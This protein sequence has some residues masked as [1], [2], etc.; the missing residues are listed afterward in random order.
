LADGHGA[1]IWLA[2]H[3]PDSR[4]LLNISW[5]TA[6]LGC[7]ALGVSWKCSFYWGYAEL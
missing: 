6:F 5:L 7:G 1:E 3:D 4:K 2:W